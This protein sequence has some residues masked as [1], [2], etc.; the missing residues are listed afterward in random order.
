MPAG[1]SNILEPN[2][3]TTHHRKSK[4]RLYS[5]MNVL[6]IVLALFLLGVGAIEFDD[7]LTLAPTQAQNRV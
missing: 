4:N 5:I 2:M 1:S 7:G 6:L 3:K